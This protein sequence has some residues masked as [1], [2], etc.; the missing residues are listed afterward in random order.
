M[1]KGVIIT[2]GKPEIIDQIVVVTTIDLL[3][4]RHMGG[5]EKNN[6]E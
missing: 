4:C 5:T 1:Q 6:N 2:E 3:L